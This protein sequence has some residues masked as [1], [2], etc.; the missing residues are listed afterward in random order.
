MNT[1]FSSIFTALPI[2]RIVADPPCDPSY[3]LVKRLDLKNLDY[4]QAIRT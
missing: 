1:I 4:N 3:A 2:A